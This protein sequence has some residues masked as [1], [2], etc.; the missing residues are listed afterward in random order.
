M[1][2]KL[3]QKSKCTHQRKTHATPS[4]HGL[5][6]MQGEIDSAKQFN[7]SEKSKVP[8]DIAAKSD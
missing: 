6:A 7:L 2:F 4:P 1:Y 3:H 8:I 5:M